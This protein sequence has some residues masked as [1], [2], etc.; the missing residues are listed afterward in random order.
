MNRRVLW[1]LVGVVVLGAVVA[2]ALNTDRGKAAAGD[3]LARL[4]PKFGSAGIAYPPRQVAMLAFK[5]NRMLELHARNDESAAWT[6]VT[7]YP[8]LAMGD[9]VAEDLFVI[10]ALTGKENVRIVVSPT[11]FRKRR[12]PD[13]SG[14]PWLPARY[15][16]I[17]VA[18]LE[19]PD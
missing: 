12:A 16:Q 2:I 8:I 5:D 6:K 10:A 13:M 14:P 18:L 4:A 3:V 17:R 1:F 15:E 11:D 19:Y 7:E 9:D